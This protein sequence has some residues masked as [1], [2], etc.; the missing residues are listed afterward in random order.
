NAIARN[1][2]YEWINEGEAVATGIEFEYEKVMNNKNEFTGYLTYTNAKYNGPRS[3]WAD[4]TKNDYQNGKFASDSENL[5]RVPDIKM[6]LNYSI[7]ALDDVSIMLG[8]EFTGKQY[9][10]YYADNGVDKNE[11]KRTSGYWQANLRIEKVDKET[12]IKYFL[13]AKN[14]TDKIQKDRRTDDAAFIYMP[15]TGR[16]LYIGMEMGF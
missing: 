15:L 2:D 12:G 9:I 4:I 11:I 8:S 1:Y 16:I 5:P 3:D 7:K 14:L 13:G 6:G 10:D